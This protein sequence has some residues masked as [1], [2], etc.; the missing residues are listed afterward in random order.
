MDPSLWLPNAD[1][2]PTARLRLLCFAHAG[3]GAAPFFRWNQVLPAQIAVCP[4]RRPGRESAHAEPLLRDIKAIAA[5][6]VRALQS[7]PPLPTVLLGH[8]LG[9]LVA[10][11]V[12]RLMQ[13]LG[14]TPELLI[15]SAKPPPHVPSLLPNLS[16]LPNDR[17]L[18]ELDELYGGIPKEIKAVPELLEMMLPVLRADM[19]A[20]EN[21]RH[22]PGPRLRCPIVACHGDADRAVDPTTQGA[23]GELTDCG[24]TRRTFPGGHF[25]VYE[26]GSGFLAWLRDE[27]SE[28]L[29]ARLPA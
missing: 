4:V 15:V 16:H 2:R 18:R 17:F 3:G 23:W 20:S 19:A 29:R 26:P 24:L 14:A 8:S 27:L 6:S 5:G 10:Y 21:Y 22:T 7:L 28:E 1:L 9:G 11:E 25:Y 13:S 12:A